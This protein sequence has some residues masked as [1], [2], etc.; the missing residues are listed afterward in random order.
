MGVQWTIKGKSIKMLVSQNYRL[1]LVAGWDF[2]DMTFWGW[3]LVERA[4]ESIE[5]FSESSASKVCTDC[6]RVWNRTTIILDRTTLTYQTNRIKRSFNF[7]IGEFQVVWLEW[8]PMFPTRTSQNWP[9]T[10]RTLNVRKKR[11]F[12]SLLVILV[13]HSGR[14]EQEFEVRCMILGPSRD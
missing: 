8:T 14:E 10:V 3:D 7:R 13:V 4:R 12:S 5:V 11:Y 9:R 6:L 1:L 2:W